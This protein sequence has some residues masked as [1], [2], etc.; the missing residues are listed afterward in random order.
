[1][2]TT[3]REEEQEERGGR[4][5]LGPHPSIQRPSDVSSR[6]L[7]V[8][9]RSSSHMNTAQ[10]ESHSRFLPRETIWRN[11]ETVGHH[12]ISS[13]PQRRITSRQYK[14]SISLTT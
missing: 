8:L 11:G 5:V 6:L 3:S 2:E 9:V 10:S 13:Q 7:D 4:S 1:M 12:D 14:L